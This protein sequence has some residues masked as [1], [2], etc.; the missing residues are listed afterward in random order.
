MARFV[1]QEETFKQLEEMKNEN[2]E[3]LIRLKEE[4]EA[5]QVELQH[6]KYSGESRLVG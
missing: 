4:K 1:A 5:L 3:D 6:L 2:E